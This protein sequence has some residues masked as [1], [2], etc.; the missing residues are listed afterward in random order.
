MVAGLAQGLPLIEAVTIAK[1]F[2]T[3]AIRHSLAVGHGSRPVDI[4]MPD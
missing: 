1:K 2:V 3:N 4:A